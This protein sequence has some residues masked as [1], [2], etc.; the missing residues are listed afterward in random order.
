MLWEPPL[1]CPRNRVSPLNF[2]D[3]SERNRAFASMAAVAGGACPVF[4]ASGVAERI[5]TG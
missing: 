4:S 3:W 1:S 5:I 2:L